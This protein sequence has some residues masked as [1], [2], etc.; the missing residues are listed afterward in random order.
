[1]SELRIESVTIENIKAITALEFKAGTV[2]VISGRNGVGKS[3]VLDALASVFGGGHDPDLIRRGAKSGTVTIG[4]SNGVVMKKSITPKNSTMKVTTQD[5]GLVKGPQSYVKSL[6]HGMAFDPVSFVEANAKRR[7]GFLL[8]AMPI[9][10]GTDALRKALAGRAPFRPMDLAEFNALLDGLSDQRTETN[11]SLKQLDGTIAQLETSLPPDG[12][13]DWPA[14]AESLQGR[15][16]EAEQSIAAAAG[17]RDLWIEKGKASKSEDFGSKIQALEKQIL[18]FRNAR[19][20][21]CNEIEREGQRM[22]EEDV[23]G[24]RESLQALSG[25]LGSARQKAEEATRAAATRETVQGFRDEAASKQA[26]S[27]DLQGC[28]ENMRD[29]KTGVLSELP[30]PGVDIRDGEVYVDD[31]PWGHVNKSAQYLVAAQVSS[32][33]KC[34]LP[35]KVLDCAE[36]LDA[37]NLA[38]LKEGYSQ[39]GLQLAVAVVT[40]NKGLTVEADAQEVSK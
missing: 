6:T 27:E 39:A 2:T 7:L 28:I 15:V 32:L 36:Q 12:D 25:L 19:V 5:G 29:L 20:E 13:T 38:A 3:S 8:D 18:V 4:L 9:T 1:M 14:E 26:V 40:E 35:F 11:R 17:D 34:A 10:F 24:C 30:I 23:A 16:S 33:E 37:E 21:A 22:Y 31:T